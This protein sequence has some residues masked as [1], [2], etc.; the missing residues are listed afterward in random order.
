M[1]AKPKPP[2]GQVIA[3]DSRLPESDLAPSDP[4]NPRNVF[5]NILVL[6][7]QTTADTR[8]D[9]AAPAREKVGFANPAPSPSPSP[10][11]ALTIRW[12]IVAAIAAVVGLFIFL[13]KK[14]NTLP[15][16][17]LLSVALIAV[18]HYLA[19]EVVKAA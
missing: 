1:A 18:L 6:G 2:Q 3:Y 12:T 16:R 17:V 4:S 14:Q 10:S 7:A 15:V 19:G 9:S 13:I 5:K 8:Y 11:A